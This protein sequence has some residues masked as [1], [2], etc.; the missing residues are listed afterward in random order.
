MLTDVDTLIR[1]HFNVCRWNLKKTKIINT[2][3]KTFRLQIIQVIEVA[4]A[5]TAVPTKN[6]DQYIWI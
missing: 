5:V 2:I 4:R 1:L 6:D 3:I